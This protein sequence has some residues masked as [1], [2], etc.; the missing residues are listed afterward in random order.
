[1]RT[2]RANFAINLLGCAG[3]EWIDNE[4]PDDAEQALEQIKA[5]DPRMVVF[6][7]SDE[8]Y[9]SIGLSLMQKLKAQDPSLILIQAGKPADE[10]PFKAAGI[11]E[12]IFARMDAIEFFNRLVVHLAEL[13]VS[14][15]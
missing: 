6:C 7:S 8:E 13:T 2:A 15:S 14:Q 11:D 4:H 9:T 12:F 10:A 5:T 3:I 1:M